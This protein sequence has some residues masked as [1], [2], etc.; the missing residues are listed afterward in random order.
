MLPASGTLQHL[1]SPRAAPTRS[2]LIALVLRH[3]PALAAVLAVAVT[4]CHLT[5]SRASLR[6][7]RYLTFDK[8]F[9]SWPLWQDTITCEPDG[10]PVGVD[11]LHQCI[12]RGSILQLCKMESARVFC[13]EKIL[14]VMSLPVKTGRWQRWKG[15]CNRVT[16]WR[17]VYVLFDACA[18]GL[19]VTLCPVPLVFINFQPNTRYTR[20]R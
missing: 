2:G 19:I 16:S 8:L 12:R 17:S 20:Q 3:L 11:L 7:R 1:P 4:T 14:R 9:E 5:M 18:L 15:R 6:E 10:R 13:R